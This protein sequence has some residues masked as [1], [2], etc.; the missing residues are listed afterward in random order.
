MTEREAEQHAAATRVGGGQVLL[1]TKRL[2]VEPAGGRQLLCKLNHDVLRDLLGVRLVL[3]ELDP[4]PVQGAR[5]ALQAFR[6][7]ID[8]V[9]DA[10]IARILVRIGEMD[11]RSVFVDGSNYGEVV[12]AIKR[13]YPAVRVCVFFH[14]CEAR[15]F[16]G[17][18]R[19]SRSLRALLVFVVNLLAERKSV[20]H[21]DALIC[22]SQ[23]DGDQL[24]RLYGRGA[25]HISPMALVDT[26]QAGETSAIVPRAR[27]VALFVGGLFYANRAG[28]QWFVRDVVPHVKTEVWIVGKGLE[29]LRESTRIP[30]GV[31][32]VGEV[33]AVAEWYRQANFVVAPIFDGSGMKTKVAEALMHGKEIIGTPE[34]FSGYEDIAGEAGIV[35]RTAGEFI[36][37]IDATASTGRPAFRQDLRALYEKRYSFAAAR[38]RMA[39]ILELSAT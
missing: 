28:I 18:L 36:A 14:N 38:Q 1:V 35:C 30:A 8:G 17:A 33:P 29:S 7:H 26:L 31:R 27:A 10:S 5:R 9:S 13:A 21:G 24:V 4:R 11:I 34:A 15:F 25:T 22:L 16:W 6:G 23:R 32:V 2:D 20:R 12:R 19:D 3:E 39:D 37:A